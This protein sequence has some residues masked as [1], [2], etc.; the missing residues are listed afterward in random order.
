MRIES[1]EDDVSMQSLLLAVPGL[2]RVWAAAVEPAGG[3]L[4]S[5]LGAALDALLPRLDQLGRDTL[6]FDFGWRHL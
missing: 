4:L 2:A 3:A 5:T 6:S 1:I